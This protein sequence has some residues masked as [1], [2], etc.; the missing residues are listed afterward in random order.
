M[1][2]AQALVERAKHQRRPKQRTAILLALTLV[3]A[4]LVVTSG[5][6]NA[7]PGDES[8]AGVQPAEVALGGQPNDCTATVAGRLPS[9]ATYEL[10][11]QNPQNG[12]TYPGPGGIS[13]ALEV[14]NDKKLDFVVNGAAVVLDVI[15]KGGQKSTHFDYD[16]NGGPGGAIADQDLH[17]PTK[18]NGNSLYS[19]SHVSVCYE[20]ADPICGQ[21]LAVEGG[22]LEGA[23]DFFA[24]GNSE[25]G[26]ENK[27]G[28]LFASDEGGQ[29][30]LNLPLVG[31][32]QVAGIGVITKTFASP[33]DFVPL[34]YAQSSA[35]SY[36]VLP[37]CALRAKATGDG[38]EF[39][40]YLND[41]SKYPSLVGI[42]DPDSG[43]S[44]VSCKVF[45]SE[46]AEGIQITV[47]LVQDD[48]FWR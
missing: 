22:L 14:R 40:P 37:W 32:G 5:T 1:E 39:D 15:I 18:G 26:C 28:Q 13:I 38:A 35:D 20:E 44:S 17:A 42:N 23:F 33:D 45:E 43:D 12:V 3:A 31:P 16:G 11:I 2:H 8:A 27:F 25:S 46:N 19:I 34:V 4:V 10:R 30:Q 41:D 24:E 47:V 29:R 9:A 48:P 6:A 7:G 36:E 21:S